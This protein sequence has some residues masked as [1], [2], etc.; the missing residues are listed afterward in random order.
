MGW[1][2]VADVDQRHPWDMQVAVHSSGWNKNS[3]LQHVGS[4]NNAGDGPGHTM[5]VHHSLPAVNGIH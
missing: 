2:G 5:S 1:Q 4:K 3:K